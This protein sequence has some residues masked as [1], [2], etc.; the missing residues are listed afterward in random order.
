MRKLV[1]FIKNRMRNDNVRQK[2]QLGRMKQLAKE[3]KCFFC[4]KNYLTVKASPSIYQSYYWYI[5][6]NDFPYI[7]STHHYLIV[8]KK[9]ITK[10]THLN[11]VAWLELLKTIGWLEKH[12]RVKGYSVF[13]RSGD[14][15]YTGATIDHLH[16]HFIAGG[17]KK[18]NGE[19]KDNILVTLGHKKTPESN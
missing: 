15:R 2:E 7:G 16:F 11:K 1:R 14:M 13:V 4:K 9:H 12:T 6:K 8:Y 5:K 17:P 3:G 19:I 10:P 18:K